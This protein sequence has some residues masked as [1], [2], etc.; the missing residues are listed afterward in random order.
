VKEKV[1]TFHDILAKIIA[2]RVEIIRGEVF[3][4]IIDE[5]GVY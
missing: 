5:E 3:D 1:F 2:L 4:E